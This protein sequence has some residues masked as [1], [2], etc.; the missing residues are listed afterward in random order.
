MGASR[1]FVNDTLWGTQSQR[2]SRR[3]SAPLLRAV[4]SWRHEEE[5]RYNLPRE[6]LPAPKCVL[7]RVE[8]RGKTSSQ[9]PDDTVLSWCIDRRSTSDRMGMG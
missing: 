3:I 4:L 7:F 2:L 1:K 9:R 5:N 6:A 8:R